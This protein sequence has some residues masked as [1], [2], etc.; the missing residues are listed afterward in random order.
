MDGNSDCTIWSGIRQRK[1]TILH[2]RS[3]PDDMLFSGPIE[4]FEVQKED[5][6]KVPSMQLLALLQD[7][8]KL[9]GPLCCSGI[10]DCW[11]S[12]KHCRIYQFWTETDV[13]CAESFWVA[14]PVHTQNAFALSFRN[15]SQNTSHFC[16]V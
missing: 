7:F 15:E 2:P 1:P 6:P 8:S 5:T 14:F 3:E 4:E 13:C 11:L 10:A 12:P 16:F 9:D